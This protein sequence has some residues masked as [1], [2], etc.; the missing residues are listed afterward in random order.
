[1]RP[2]SSSLALESAPRATALLLEGRAGVQASQL[3]R[4]RALALAN[5]PLDVSTIRT[6]MVAHLQPVGRVPLYLSDGTG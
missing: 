5:Y 4:V 3:L 1:M 2:C 6:S